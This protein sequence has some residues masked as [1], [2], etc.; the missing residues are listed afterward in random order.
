MNLQ[1]TKD[2]KKA[3]LQHCGEL[4]NGNSPYDTVALAYINRAYKALYAGGDIFG[5]DCSEPWTWAKTKKPLLL[6]IDTEIADGSVTLTNGSY[7]GTF[8]TVPKIQLDNVSPLPDADCTGWYLKL[9][10]YDDYFQI[11]FHVPGTTTFQ[12]DQA[13][14]QTTQTTNFTCFPIEYDLYDDTIIVD[15]FSKYLDFNIGAGALSATL[16]NGVYSIADFCTEVVAKLGTA[17]GLTYSCTFNTTLRKFTLTQLSGTAFVPTPSTGT[18]YEQSAWKLLG[19]D[20]TDLSGSLTYTGTR[21][22]NAI[23]R[24]IRPIATYRNVSPRFIA[25]EDSGK[26]YGIDSSAM[27]KKFPLTQMYPSFPD[28]FCEL[29]RRDNGTVRIRF[30]SYPREAMRAEVDYIPMAEV[31]YDSDSS[32]PKITEPYRE[33]LVYAAAYYLFL[34]KVDDRSANAADQAKATLQA[35]INDYRSNTELTNNTYGRLIP[36][37]VNNRPWRVIP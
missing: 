27:L 30:S 13:W 18:H 20:M 33:Y 12:L 28:K 37:A 19:F 32:I 34:D 10:G 35:M 29:F 3:V 23:Q 7:S 22:L 5:V 26:I 4:T 31:L 24:L 25:P 36:R 6:R 16:S 21:A 11:R 15:D 8:S 1:T 14:F 17:S 9:P 2:I